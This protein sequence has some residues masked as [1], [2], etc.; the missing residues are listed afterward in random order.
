[1]KALKFDIEIPYWCSF[2]EFGTVSS[3]L[4]YPFP[5]PPTLFGLILNA[6]GKFALHTINDQNLSISIQKEYFHAYNN[7]RFAVIIRNG[8][9]KIDDYAN[10]QKRNRGSDT[11]ARHLASDLKAFLFKFLPKDRMKGKQDDLR[12]LIRDVTKYNIY[13]KKKIGEKLETYSEK[14]SFNNWEPISKFI[15]EY[16]E[17]KE[18]NINKSWQKTQVTRQRIILPY[19]TVLLISTNEDEYC[20]ENI[21]NF[22]LNPKRPLYC[23]ES[24]DVTITTIYPIAEIENET[25]SSN[26]T[27]IIPGVYPNSQIINIPIS[28]RYQV[29]ENP[30]I[31]CSIPRG[32]IGKEIKC[33]NLEGDNFVFLEINGKV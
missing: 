31:V 10:I 28:L 3:H 24:D 19:Y 23:G 16:W 9:I 20:I 22:L 26:I 30:R 7:M 17:N 33:Y 15:Y 12:N 1:M 14:M 4:T 2:K 25:K 8:G 32:N 21:Y 11:I 18:Y 29:I 5:P 27:S 13:L 6:L